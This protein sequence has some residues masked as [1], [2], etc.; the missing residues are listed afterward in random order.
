M[1]ALSTEHLRME[2][3]VSSCCEYVTQK[4][5]SSHLQPCHI[6]GN[7]EQH[8]QYN[9]KGLPHPTRAD[10]QLAG[11]MAADPLGPSLTLQVVPA[12]LWRGVQRFS[13]VP[14]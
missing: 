1:P 11:L 14:V 3:R 10:S 12:T 4:H 8:K 5:I 13:E 2:G 7:C 6:A 9:C